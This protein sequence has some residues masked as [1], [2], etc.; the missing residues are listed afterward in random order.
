MSFPDI[1]EFE[2]DDVAY[3]MDL[4]DLEVEVLN[5]A[6]PDSPIELGHCKG[7]MRALISKL[8]E[9]LL[10]ALPLE[11]NNGS[12]KGEV[13]MKLNLTVNTSV[14]GMFPMIYVAVFNSLCQ[15]NLFCPPTFPL[16]LPLPLPLCHRPPLL[17]LPQMISRQ[18]A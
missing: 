3:V 17:L 4:L 8:N 7:N 5:M 6:N 10:I 13:R 11:R 14:L 9:P 12:K 18:N 1:Y 2:I 15:Y 16:S